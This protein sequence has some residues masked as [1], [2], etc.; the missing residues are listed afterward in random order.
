[1]GN[2]RSGTHKNI[3]FKQWIDI[4]TKP[5]CIIVNQV[6]DFLININ[7]GKL[8]KKF[9][10]KIDTQFLNGELKLK[11]NKCEFFDFLK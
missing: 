1:M 9:L 2:G 8:M 7:K 10:K 5:L 4:F 3:K 11:K 6:K